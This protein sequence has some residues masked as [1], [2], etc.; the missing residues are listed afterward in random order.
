MKNKEDLLAQK[1]RLANDALDLAKDSLSD[2]RSCMGECGVRDLVQIF[3][4]AIKAHRDLSADII[5]AE[6]TE[7]KAEKDLAKDKEYVSKVDDLLK[8]LSQGNTK[9]D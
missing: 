2:L 8:K 5:S 7:S 4:S 1:V 3:N 9:E 6:E